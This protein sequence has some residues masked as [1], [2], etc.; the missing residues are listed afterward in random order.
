MTRHLK[1][2]QLKWSPSKAALPKRLLP[3][4]EY[5]S[6]LLNL[7]SNAPAFSLLQPTDKIGTTSVS[8]S[9]KPKF[10]HFVNS[11]LSVYA[12]KVA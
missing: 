1:A 11:L 4:L 8:V 3:N 9:L 10:A 2:V 12:A 5:A 6:T 7:G